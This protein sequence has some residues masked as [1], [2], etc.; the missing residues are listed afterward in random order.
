MI[1]LHN[2]G[3]KGRDWDLGI[4]LLTFCTSF[5]DGHFC[6]YDYF[7]GVVVAKDLSILCCVLRAIELGSLLG[8]F[9]TCIGINKSERKKGEG[10]VIHRARHPFNSLPSITNKVRWVISPFRV[11]ATKQ[12]R[13]SILI[14]L[15]P[16]VATSLWICLSRDA[17][18]TKP[19]PCN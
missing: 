17:L 12:T 3:I 15:G 16:L 1:R 4:H 14:A 9:D 2:V 18:A 8:L 11:S 5:G 7:V 19:F 13:S 6:G 10:G